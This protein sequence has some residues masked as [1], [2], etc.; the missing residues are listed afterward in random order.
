M[1][2][3]LKPTLSHSISL[4]EPGSGLTLESLSSKVQDKSLEEDQS[5]QQPPSEA[6][7][8]SKL[9]LLKDRNLAREKE[10]ERR[11]REAV[12]T[13]AP[14]ARDISETAVSPHWSKIRA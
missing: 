10:Q 11:R 14:W 3:N 8:V 6:Q 1:L 4:R 12:S 7:D 2:R 9:W 5:E 13:L